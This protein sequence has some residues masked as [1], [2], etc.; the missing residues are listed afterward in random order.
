VERA[1]RDLH[2]VMQHIVFGAAWLEAAGRIRLGL[3]PQNP[4]F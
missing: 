3:A 4:M 2:A 1:H